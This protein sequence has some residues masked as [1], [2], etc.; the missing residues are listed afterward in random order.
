MAW[1]RN[2]TRL[3]AIVLTVIVIATSIALRK[4]VA[5]Q[6]T[7]MAIGMVEIVLIAILVFG[8]VRPRARN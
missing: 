5:D 2:R 7:R 6:T 3:I 1:T 4:A 8:F